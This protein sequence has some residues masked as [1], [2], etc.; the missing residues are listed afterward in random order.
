MKKWQ[1]LFL[2]SFFS[3]FPLHA[4]E[5]QAA[6]KSAPLA[7]LHRVEFS[8]AGVRSLARLQDGG[9]HIQLSHQD[10][11]S[12]RALVALS[13]WFSL[14]AQGEWLNKEK[15]I[16][17]VAAYKVH[18]YGAVLKFTLTPDTQP[19]VYLLAGAGK[20]KREFEYSY[21][22]HETSST[23]YVLAAVGVEAAVWRGVF[24]AAEGS[25]LY[26]KHAHYGNFFKL[27]HR[28]EPQISIRAGIK[29]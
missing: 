22:L 20:T 24:V 16:P 19:Q 4:Q 6:E 13:P 27:T 15:D 10:G 11:F 9:G 25:A 18:R 28:V 21:P 17:A 23:G 14:G 1:A 29:F 3:L 2:I 7:K 8:V 12:G 5:S 26:N